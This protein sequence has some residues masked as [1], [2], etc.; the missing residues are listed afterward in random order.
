MP[1]MDLI[2]WSLGRSCCDWRRN[3]ICV[4]KKC[5]VRDKCTLI[6]NVDF[7]CKDFCPLD[8]I[9]FGSKKEEFR[10]FYEPNIVTTYY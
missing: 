2:I 4:N 10:K 7:D 1:N 5:N 6:K 3:P 8:G 9:C